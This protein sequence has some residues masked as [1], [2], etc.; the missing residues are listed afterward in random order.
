MWCRDCGELI[1]LRQPFQDWSTDATGLCPHCAG[2]LM[3]DRDE[4]H[5]REAKREDD[6]ENKRS[7]EEAG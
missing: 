1:G 3:R 2:M 5:T 7:E 4:P 6:G